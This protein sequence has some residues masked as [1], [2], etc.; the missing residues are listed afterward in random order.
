M[1]GKRNS[2]MD[3]VNGIETSVLISGKWLSSHININKKL[4]ESIFI[5]QK[6]SF[7]EM[8][9]HMDAL[10]FFTKENTM[11]TRNSISASGF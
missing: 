9:F 2:T 5:T 1:Q 10:D 6:I 4:I 3:I 7:D 11:S 8:S